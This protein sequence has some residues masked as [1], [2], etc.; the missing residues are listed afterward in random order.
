MPMN[1]KRF[2][3]APVLAIFGVLFVGMVLLSMLGGSGYQRVDTSAAEQ[4][5][6]TGKVDQVR[7]LNNER[8]ELDLKTG[9]TYSSSI[10]G[11]QDASKVFAYYVD[12]RGP[13]IVALLDKYPPSKGF[14][15][16]IDQPS[17]F[18]TLLVNVLPVLLL[19]VLFWFLMGQMQGGGNRV[20]QFGKSRAKLATKDMP[21]VTFQDVAGCDEAVEELHEIKEFL[22]E[23]AKF[24]AV[25]AKIPK[26]VLLYGPPGTGKTLLARAVA[27]EAGVPFYSIS[28]SDF[29]E[30]FVGV[31]ASRVRDLFEQATNI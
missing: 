19:I 8:M 14:T 20:M 10:D 25:G 23:P 28:G 30:M 5:I 1:V 12:A 9:V 4:L 3:R 16:Q 29:V 13:Q 24:L 31:G 11:V 2:G 15:D 27:G 17:W 22:Q 6:S 26:G 21:K 18:G 7:L